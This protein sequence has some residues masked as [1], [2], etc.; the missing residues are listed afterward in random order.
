MFTLTPARYPRLHA[1]TALCRPSAVFSF[2]LLLVAPALVSAGQDPDVLRVTGFDVRNVEV[3][4]GVDVEIS[5]GATAELLLRGSPASLSPEPF[6]VRGQT[7]VLGAAAGSGKSA[8][9]VAFKLTLPTLDSLLISGSGDVF[10]RPLEV[11]NF[12]LR[13]NGSGDA[14]LFALH[15]DTA[16]I[17]MR[18]AGDVQVAELSVQ[19]LHLRLSGAGDIQLGSVQ[20]ESLQA[21]LNGAGDIAVADAGRSA[22]LAVTVVGSGDVNF[23]ALVMDEANVTVVG[24]GSVRLGPSVR[25]QATIMGSGDITYVGEPD[26]DQNVI[27]SG[28]LQQD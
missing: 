12:S 10:V 8:G 7:L 17:D 13:V 19:E 28:Q 23:A 21:V 3:Q 1:L 25:L 27:G 14:H 5:Q 26:I 18:G 4:G 6:H 16:R 20:T 11:A 24:S 9:G 2:C 22:A 15:A